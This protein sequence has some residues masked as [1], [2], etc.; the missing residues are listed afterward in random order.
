MQAREIMTKRPDYL[1]ADATIREVAER[2]HRDDSG[3][4]PLVQ[5]DRIV[6]AV[7]DRDIAIRAVAGGKTLDDKASSVATDDILY[8]YEDTEAK[9]LLKEMHKRQVQR[10]VVLNNSDDKHF[11][12]VVTLSD[13]A[14]HCEDDA[15]AREI[16]SCCKH[17]H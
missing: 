3:F 16:V 8:A 14:D 1:T 13:I 6:C 17:Y 4:E 10:L 12:G 9:D 7:T 15:M 5:G 11:S 2:M